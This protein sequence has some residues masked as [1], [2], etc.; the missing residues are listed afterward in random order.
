MFRSR[1]LLQL[2][3]TG[4]LLSAPA[5][6]ARSAFPPIAASGVPTDASAAN[7]CSQ[8][9][10]PAGGANTDSRGRLQIMVDNLTYTPGVKKRIKVRIDHSEAQRWGFQ[11]TARQAGNTRTGAGSFAEDANTTLRCGGTPALTVPPCAGEPEPQ[12]I[13]HNSAST[14]MGTRGGVDWEFEWTPPANE[15]GDIILYAASIAAN[16]NGNN[17]GD[18]LYTT[19][20]TLRAQGACNLT[21]RPNV[22]SVGNA[23]SFARELSPSALASVFGLNFEV[24]GR[25]RNVS[26]GDLVDGRFPTSLACVAV[27]VGGKRAPVTYVQTDQIN[28]QVPFDVPSGAVPLVVILN[29]DRQNELRSD[30]ATVTVNNHSPAFFTFGGKSIAALNAQGTPVAAA[31]DVPGGVAARRGD[32]VSLYGTGFGL[33]EPVYQSGEI[34]TGAVSLRDRVTVTVGG[35]ILAASD[36]LYAG[37]APGNITGLQQINIR[38][39]MSTAPGN[40]AIS[41]SV[42]GVSTPTAGA[43]IPVQ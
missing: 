21:T 2:L 13:S 39:P 25:T 11:F 29:P 17:Q 38:V 31:A 15:V 16:G 40:V 41:I 9:H 35:T 12:F 1:T 8:C 22:R 23:A 6:F 30:I 14:R 26:A 28:F 5:L 43:V 36:V 42:G 24:A 20:I 27:T 10:Q 33:S 4:A 19:S 37:L 34:P 32:V 18:S 3:I 7:A